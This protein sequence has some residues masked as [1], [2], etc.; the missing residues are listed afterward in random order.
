M[1]F[2]LLLLILIVTLLMIIVYIHYLYVINYNANIY[3][4]EQSEFP[5]NIYFPA[6]TIANSH[7]KTLYDAVNDAVFKFNST[8]N[9]DFFVINQSIFKYPNILVFRIAC[10][11]HDGCLGKFDNKGGIMAHATYPPIRKVC[12]DCEDLSYK[13]L[14]LVIMHEFGHSIGLEHTDGSD[15]MSLMKP[16]IDDRLTGFSEH[17]IIRIKRFYRFLK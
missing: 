11:D 9:F 16:Y 12:I 4:Y 13:P 10:G 5:L 2:S 8:F 6:E 3:L 1:S 14:Y 7:F 15:V 17:D